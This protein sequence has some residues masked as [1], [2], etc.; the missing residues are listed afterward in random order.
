M[1]AHSGSSSISLSGTNEKAIGMACPILF[2]PSDMDVKQWVRTIK[3]AGLKGLILTCK[4]HDGFC[5]WSSE[6]TEY[7]IENNSYRNGKG[8]IVREVANGCKRILPVSQIETTGICINISRAKA[9]FVISNVE[10]F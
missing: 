2:N 9:C 3:D 6:Y 4:H 8:D 10:M 7:F 5:L 1:S